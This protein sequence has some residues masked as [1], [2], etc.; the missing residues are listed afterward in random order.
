MTHELYA[1]VHGLPSLLTI[2]FDSEHKAIL[3]AVEAA[4]VTRWNG[5]VWKVRSRPA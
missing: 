3:A 4:A 5:V 2:G 1:E